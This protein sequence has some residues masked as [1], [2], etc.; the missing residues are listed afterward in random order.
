MRFSVFCFHALLIICNTS[1][2]NV[3]DIYIRDDVYE[4]YTTFVNNRDVLQ[5]TDFS[6]QAIRRDVVDMIIA[7]QALSLG[8]FDY[9]FAWD[10]IKLIVKANKRCLLVALTISLIISQAK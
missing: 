6:G 2:A 1:Y 5:I 9:H 10:I 7:Q 8:G 4:D 3:I